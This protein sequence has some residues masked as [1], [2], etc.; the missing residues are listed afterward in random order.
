[1]FQLPRCRRIRRADLRTSALRA[2]VA[3]LRKPEP[4]PTATYRRLNP[5]TS[6]VQD[7]QNSRQASGVQFM[8]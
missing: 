6:G 3:G 7:I 2:G 5:S 8:A 4:Q 1:M